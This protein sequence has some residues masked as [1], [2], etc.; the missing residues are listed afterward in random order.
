MPGVTKIDFY[1]RIKREHTRLTTRPHTNIYVYCEVPQ[2]IVFM[3]LFFSY[4]I[5]ICCCG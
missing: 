2:P 4:V 5:C 3:L 1:E